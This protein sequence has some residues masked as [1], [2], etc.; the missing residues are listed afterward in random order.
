MRVSREEKERSRRRIVAAAS[1]R[2]R[3]HGIAGTSVAD[4]MADAELTHGGFYRHF[5]S[6]D[7]LLAAALEE[8]FAGMLAPIESAGTPRERAEAIRRFVAR[9]VSAEHAASAADGCPIAALSTEIPREADAARAA[10]SQGVERTLTA[11]SD[12]GDGA[13]PADRDEARERLITLVGA[14]VLARSSTPRTARDI[15]RVAR[16]ALDV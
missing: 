1:R 2:F 4:V 12:L 6:K 10:F 16:R 7:E 3:G 5:A 14:V 13:T 8:T 15:L 9:Y 11:L